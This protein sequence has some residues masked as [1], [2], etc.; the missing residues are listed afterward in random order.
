MD[1]EECL[2][3][4]D[5]HRVLTIEEK[6]TFNMLKD[7]QSS[8]EDAYDDSINYAF[9]LLENEDQNDIAHAL[10]IQSNARAMYKEFMIPLVAK[11]KRLQ[12]SHERL[13]G[14]IWPMELPNVRATLRSPHSPF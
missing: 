4:K 12:W 10:D 5:K 11:F 6:R 1:F 13:T 3:Q 7:G 2:A 9:K 8:I 14:A